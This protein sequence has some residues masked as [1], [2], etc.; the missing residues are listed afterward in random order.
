[1]VDAAVKQTYTT[2]PLVY[3]DSF[4]LLRYDPRGNYQD[5]IGWYEW[6]EKYAEPWGRAGQFYSELPM[7]RKSAVVVSGWYYYVIQNNG[8]AIEMYDTA[9]TK[10]RELV[11]V[12]PQPSVPIT[13]AD[14][15]VVL[16]H[17]S[18]A[19]PRGSPIRLR[20]FLERIPVPSTFPPYG[21]E[22]KRR[23]TMLR[24]DDD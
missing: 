3:R 12:D 1:L 2:S 4:A 7:G 19:Q 11:P 10:L 16:A 13:Q 24:V 5:S 17:R 14:V 21:W 6:T 9:G 15:D 23:L 8:L 18:A 22:G 20:D